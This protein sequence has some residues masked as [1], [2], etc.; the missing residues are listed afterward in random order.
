MSLPDSPS[1]DPS[2]DELIT[3]LRDYKKYLSTSGQCI[4]NDC[5]AIKNKALVIASR[6]QD[7]KELVE[8]VKEEVNDS[9]CSNTLPNCE[10]R[11]DKYDWCLYCR[12]KSIQAF[13]NNPNEERKG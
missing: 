6:L 3:T 4:D 8:K 2:T 1:Q 7:Y 13:E 9:H 10:W 12:L 5:H 11:L